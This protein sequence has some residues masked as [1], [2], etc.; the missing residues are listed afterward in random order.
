MEYAEVVDRIKQGRIAPVYLLYGPQSFM[1]EAVVG[2][3]REAV[4]AHRHGTFA[5]ETFHGDED[6]GSRI[7]AAAREIPMLVPR[8]LIVVR[9]AQALAARAESVEALVQYLEQP[10]AT[11]ILAL[12]APTFDARTRLARK[13]AE[14]GIVLRAEKVA[15][16]ELPPFVRHHG[17]ALGVDLPPDAVSALL[18]A[19]GDDLAALHDGISKLALYVEEGRPATV[20]DVQAVVAPSRQHSVFELV[21]AIGARDTARAFELVQRLVDQG[22]APLK[23]LGLFAR[24]IRQ[25][26]DLKAGRRDSPRLAGLR[27]FVR[28]KVQAQADRFSMRDLVRALEALHRA[29]LAL[30]SKAFGRDTEGPRALEALVLE[31]AGTP[32]GRTARAGRPA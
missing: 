26:I 2:A 10:S 28:D 7:A 1:I 27:D 22:E 25:L 31:M 29:D 20:E 17:R 30:K 19:C 8:R 23:A 32:A 4:E 3:L 18:D 24:Q 15:F 16:R 9:E 6:H 13:A 14:V 12:C 21:D 11:T 5:C